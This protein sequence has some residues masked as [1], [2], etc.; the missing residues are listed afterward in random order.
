M[1]KVYL[2]IW[3]IDRETITKVFATREAAI[4]ECIEWGLDYY[5]DECTE[6]EIRQGLNDGMFGL[7]D[8]DGWVRIEEHKVNT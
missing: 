6:E 1:L 4:A 8:R 7:D 5:P 3:D 2:V